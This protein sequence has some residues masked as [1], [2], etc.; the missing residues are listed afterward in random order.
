MDVFN[1]SISERGN[2]TIYQI[3]ESHR[4]LKSHVMMNNQILDVQK[5][6][7]I[8]LEE[9]IHKLETVYTD[10]ETLKKYI[11]TLQTKTNSIENNI[12]RNNKSFSALE[13]DVI[14]VRGALIDI[15]KKM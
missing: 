14:S 1:N 6:F 10:I 11:I 5:N 7:I 12:E 8:N 15:K 9:K 13:K 4:I 3:Q 2:K